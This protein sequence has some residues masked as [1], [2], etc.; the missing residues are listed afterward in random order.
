MLD[1]AAPDFARNIASLKPDIVVDMIAFNASKD[2]VPLMDALAGQV[3][4]LLV[5]GSIWAHGSST[6][7]PL[8]EEDDLNP[9]GEYGIEKMQIHPR[10]AEALGAQPLPRHG[11]ASGTYRRPGASPGQSAWQPQLRGFFRAHARAKGA[12]AQLRH[13]N[14]ASRTRGG[15]RGCILRGH[16]RGQCIVR[17]AFPCGIAGGAFAARLRYRGGRLVRP[18]KRIWNFCPSPSGPRR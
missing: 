7:S 17:T 16:P 14:A 11:G 9:F 4:H 8:D 13:G 10:G 18:K 5:C 12:A 3:E 2:L 1:T 15:C 6:A